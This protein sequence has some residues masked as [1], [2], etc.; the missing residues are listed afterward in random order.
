MLVFLRAKS[1]SV[2]IKIQT[3]KRRKRKD[4]NSKSEENLIATSYCFYKIKIH[5]NKEKT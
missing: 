5:I 3:F 2:E 1:Q 4:Q